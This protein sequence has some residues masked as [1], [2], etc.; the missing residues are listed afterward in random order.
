MKF[1]KLYFF[2]ITISGILAVTGKRSKKRCGSIYGNCPSGQCCNKYGFCGKTSAFCS[3]KKG[4]QS[5]FGKCNNN[6]KVNEI[7]DVSKYDEI[8]NYTLA[9]ENVDGVIIR[10]GYRGYS[11]GNLV[12]DYKL[13]THYNGFKGKIK[14]GYYIFSQATNTTEAREEANA[15]HDFIKD[16]T[17]PDFPL[18]WDSEY[19][20]EENKNGRADKLSVD[21]RTEC[22]IAFINR[23]EELGYKPGVYASEY[24]FKDNLN[25]EKIVSTGA[26]IWVANYSNKPNTRVYDAWQYTETGRV[27]GIDND[28]DLSHVYAN[29]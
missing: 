9:A 18:F 13:E 29:W 15:L 2:I 10:A 5:K 27:D 20:G 19:S 16:K 22:A 28:V 25:Y 23:I 14:I 11:T 8:G 21:T 7:I 17:K 3:V 6:K 24:W 12:E 26:S 4:C 1:L